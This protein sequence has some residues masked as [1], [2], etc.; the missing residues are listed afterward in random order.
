MVIPQK[1]V[2][3]IELVDVESLKFSYKRKLIS[4]L[5]KKADEVL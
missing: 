1:I 3:L 2:K 5:V 4:L